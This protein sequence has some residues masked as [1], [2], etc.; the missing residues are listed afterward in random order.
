MGAYP[1]AFPGTLDGQAR[2]LWP[3]DLANEHFKV[4]GSVPWN[5]LVPPR[6]AEGGGEHAGPS[7]LG[8]SPATTEEGAAYAGEPAPQAA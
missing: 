1:R 4:I 7:R 6:V 8:G 5:E 2:L 3:V